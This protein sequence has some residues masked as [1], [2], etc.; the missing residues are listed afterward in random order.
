MAGEDKMRRKMDRKVVAGM[1]REFNI[2]VFFMDQ[3]ELYRLDPDNQEDL[4]FVHS[5]DEAYSKLYAHGKDV[6][7]TRENFIF[8]LHRY[9]FKI[10]REKF[11]TYTR[12]YEDMYQEAAVAILENYDRYDKNKGAITT[13]FKTCIFHAAF[14][15]IA[16][17]VLHTTTYYFQMEQEIRNYLREKEKAGE[18]VPKTIGAI[19]VDMKGRGY[20][21]IN[22]NGAH[23]VFLC[24]Q[25]RYASVLEFDTACYENLMAADA[26][27][28]GRKE[29]LD[30]PRYMKAWMAQDDPEDDSLEKLEAL[31]KI[32]P[33]MS[34]ILTK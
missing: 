10:F 30:A 24:Q 2:P 5:L 17:K 1:D 18:E 16:E 29:N 23:H 4:E 12:Y 6:V 31:R 13:F 19:V 11:P 27:F 21:K 32:L 20:K 28:E 7:I 25:A 14:V 15:Y 26:S 33:R 34:S 3:K 8:A 22:M 9:I